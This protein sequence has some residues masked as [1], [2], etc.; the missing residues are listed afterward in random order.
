MFIP[1]A[2]AQ[3]MHTFLVLGA[4]QLSF[5]TQDEQIQQYLLDIP[6]VEDE[7]CPSKVICTS[8]P[9][10]FPTTLTPPLGS[11]P[12]QIFEDHSDKP[13]CSVKPI[14]PVI[15][16]TESELKVPKMLGMEE[17]F[18]KSPMAQLQ[19]FTVPPPFLQ[20]STGMGPVKSSI[21]A[22]VL[23][24]HGRTWNPVGILH[25]IDVM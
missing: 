9:T 8:N 14:T 20:E 25:L 18:E 3:F 2:N 1:A 12:L 11:A 10:S 15:T 23:V 22:T 21:P 6:M 19:Y 4:Y 17:G 5:N 16:E 24:E 13:S 7:Q